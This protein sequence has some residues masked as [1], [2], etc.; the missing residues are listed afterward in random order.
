MKVE[1]GSCTR[2]DIC[3][4]RNNIVEGRGSLNA[5]MMFIS[6][7]PG[8]KEDKLG[9]PFVGRAGD[10]VR[11]YLNVYG[12]DIND[13][14]ITNVIKCRPPRNR[15]P[16]TIEIENCKEYL[17]KELKIVKPKILVLF[18]NTSIATI[19]GINNKVK[20]IAG[21]PFKMNDY[22]IMPM[23]HPSYIQRNTEMI[24]EYEH[25]W[26]RLYAIF[27]TLVPDYIFE[28]KYDTHG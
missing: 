28:P 8:Y 15:T 26:K 25:H 27:K 11:F 16:N 17:I 22:V 21:S 14:Y 10:L 23:Y 3:L 19:T 7:A 9:L 18:G 13:I 24:A 20:K 1:I 5:D 4:S 12:W 6:E 2:C